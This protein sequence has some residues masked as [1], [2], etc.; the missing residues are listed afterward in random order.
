MAQAGAHV[1]VAARSKAEIEVAASAIRARGGKA[2][3]LVL[4]VTDIE[5][6]RR[7]VTAAAP[8]QIL[9]NNAGTNWPAYLGD[10]TIEDFDAIF[11]LNVR[12][13]YFMAQNVALGLN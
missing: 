4:D 11:A 1:T 7:A 2:E 12:A 8:F 9:I 10:V 3:A 5:T 13:A 6:A